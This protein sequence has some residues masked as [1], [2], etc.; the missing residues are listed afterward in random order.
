[1]KLE[2]PGGTPKVVITVNPEKPTDHPPTC[3]A[4]IPPFR[5]PKFSIKTSGAPTPTPQRWAVKLIAA[6]PTNGLWETNAR[7]DTTSTS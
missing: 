1:M 7:T 6:P 2:S 5:Y 3:P 4:L